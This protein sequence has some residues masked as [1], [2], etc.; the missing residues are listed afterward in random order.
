MPQQAG[1]RI[2][3]MLGMDQDLVE[4]GLDH[5]LVSF[6][7]AYQRHRGRDE[8]CGIN[9]HFDRGRMRNRRAIR[10]MGRLMLH[11]IDDGACIFEVL[12][13]AGFQMQIERR[14]RF[15]RPEPEP[16]VGVGARR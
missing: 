12:A 13:L 8:V 16:S 11:G 5:R 4:T 15:R 3:Q 14:Q 1:D 6:D 7:A 9:P 2:A 10:G